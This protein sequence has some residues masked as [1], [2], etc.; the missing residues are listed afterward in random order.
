MREVMLIC[1]IAD[2][3]GSRVDLLTRRSVERSDNPL[4][5]QSVLESAM[6]IY[7]A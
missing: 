2:L 6:E 1:V 4:R 3:L 5:R 7:A